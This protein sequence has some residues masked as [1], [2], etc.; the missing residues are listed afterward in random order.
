MVWCEAMTADMEKRRAGAR[1][2]LLEAG[3][4]ALPRWPWQHPKEAPVDEV[5]VRFA[6]SRAM[7]QRQ[8]IRQEELEAGLALVDAARC[9]LDA[10]ETALVFA[11]RAE[12]MTWG[13]VAQAMG[14]RSPQAAQQR[15]QR[16]SDRPRDTAT[17][18]SSGA[19]RA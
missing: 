15:F 17:D 8:P 12:G 13:Q 16:T 5:L 1:E 7:D 9:D 6:L 19:A 3:G 11:A 2:L 10:L 4:R 14:L 18:A